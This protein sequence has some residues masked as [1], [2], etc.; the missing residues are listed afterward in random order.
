MLTGDLLGALAGAAAVLVGGWLL[1]LAFLWLHRPSREL[2]GPAVRLVPDL[3][4]LVRVLLAD[5]AVPWQVRLALLG[6][7]VYLLSPIDLVPDLLPGVGA[8]DDLILCAVILRWSGRRI[9]VEGLRSRW[10]GDP[11]SFELLQRLLGL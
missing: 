4:R 3:A 8:A 1:L 6:L 2:V 7:L 9:G 5:G 10:A 11:A